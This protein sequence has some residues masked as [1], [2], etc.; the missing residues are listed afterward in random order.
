MGRGWLAVAAI[1]ALALA[2][3]QSFGSTAFSRQT[4]TVGY[5]AGYSAAPGETNRLLLLGGGAGGPGLTQF[6]VFADL[7]AIVQAEGCVPALVGAACLAGIESWDTVLISLGDGSDSAT[8]RDAQ[9]AFASSVDGG[10]GDDSIDVRNSAAESVFCG[11]GFDAAVI[12]GRD[13][14]APDCESVNSG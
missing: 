8:V 5:S 9:I 2:P 13:F 3:A 6:A 12:D 1:A 7:G 11:P 14:A 4:T 10:T